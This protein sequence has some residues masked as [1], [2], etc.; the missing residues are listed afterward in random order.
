MFEAPGYEGPVSDH[1]NGRHFLNRDPIE[2]HG[3]SS[4]FK[5]LFSTERDKW[6]SWTEN[7]TYPKPPERVGSGEL[8]ATFINH[9]TVLI[10]MDG[11][12]FLT[13]PIFSKRCS[14]V[15]WFGPKRKRAP[16][17]SMAELPPLDYIIVSHNHYDHMD[18]PSLRELV[19]L[20]PENS[21]NH[22]SRKQKIS[23]E[24]IGKCC[25]DGDGLG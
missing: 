22:E 6:P 7:K 16:G 5:F 2:E 13:D 10:Q 12:N 19:R 3:A 17:L 8:R 14:P 24:Q 20:H 1:F 15:S 21:D 25:G 9:S 4:L 18:L 23:G 11:L